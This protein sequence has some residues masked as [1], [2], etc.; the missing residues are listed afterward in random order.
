[1][2]VRLWILVE[3]IEAHIFSCKKKIAWWRE[4]QKNG[5]GDNIEKFD[6]DPC[7]EKNSCGEK[8]KC[9]KEGTFTSLKVRGKRPGKL[10][11][12]Y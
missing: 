3:K 1:M 8:Q 6:E 12:R 11:W 4:D 5:G 10:A 9:G 7:H 2:L